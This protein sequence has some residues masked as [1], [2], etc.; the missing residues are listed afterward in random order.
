MQK[1]EKGFQA[2]AREDIP[3]RV[4]VIPVFCMRESSMLNDP[5]S[6]RAHDD[7][8]GRV[9]WEEEAE[10]GG[11]TQ[12]EKE[13]WCQPERRQPKAKDKQTAADLDQKCDC[14]PFWYIRRSAKVGEHNSAVAD[15]KVTM[16]NTVLKKEFEHEGEKPTAA[17]SN[18][19]VI[20]PCITNE[21][22]IKA[23]KEIVL[24]CPPKPAPKAAKRKAQ[25]KFDQEQSL[26]KKLK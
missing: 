11:K 1:T 7:V 25:T 3:E 10:Q 14:H 4:L 19:T 26:I 24:Y 21:V 20:V 15:L 9:M 2:I 13:I 16:I 18:F 12:V 6:T 8:V 23:G 22:E 5:R 17:V